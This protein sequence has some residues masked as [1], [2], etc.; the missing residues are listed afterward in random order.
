MLADPDLG[1]IYRHVVDHEL[2]ISLYLGEE[3]ITGGPGNEAAVEIMFRCVRDRGTE[4]RHALVSMRPSVSEHTLALRLCQIFDIPITGD[5]TLRACGEVAAGNHTKGGMDRDRHISHNLLD[6]VHYTNETL[7]LP[8]AELAKII[9]ATMSGIVDL[10]II[11]CE[12][13]S[14]GCARCQHKAALDLIA[15]RDA[16][17][18][19]IGYI[20][21]C[22][23]CAHRMW[24]V[25]ADFPEV[26][27]VPSLET[28]NLS[29]W[30]FSSDL[31]RQDR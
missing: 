5:V 19:D 29:V 3:T 30:D 12:E 31:D 18:W 16:R 4:S 15:M 2:P 8:F 27:S 6:G 9:H 13:E 24:L 11:I 20:T 14:G 17:T 7:A 25:P 1:D 10:N 23:A 28:S 21:L 22:I 26:E